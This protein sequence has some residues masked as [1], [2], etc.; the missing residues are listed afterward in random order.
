MS[1][2]SV[3]IAIII[4]LFSPGKIKPYVTTEAAGNDIVA[5]AE[6]WSELGADW[7]IKIDDESVAKV[8]DTKYQDGNSHKIV[9]IGEVNVYTFSAVNDGATKVTMTLSRK[10]KSNN[11]YLIIRSEDGKLTCPY[12]GN[13]EPSAEQIKKE[14]PNKLSSIKA[15]CTKEYFL[16]GNN[17]SI[18]DF[19]VTASYT[20]DKP[21]TVSGA[22][23][24]T[25]ASEYNT[26][27]THTIE[28]S[29]TEG[30]VTSKTTVSITV[31]DG[32]ATKSAEAK[33]KKDAYIVGDVFNSDEVAL[34]VTLYDGTVLNPDVDR[35]DTSACDFNKAGTYN[36]TAYYTVDGREESSR[37]TIKVNPVPV[38]VSST[39]KTK[40][41]SYPTGAIITSD[42][43]TAEATYSDGTK[44]S[45]SVESI[46]NAT[47]GIKAER[48]E[49]KTYSVY[50][51][52]KGVQYTSE[53]TV[54]IYGVTDVSVQSKLGTNI[55]KNKNTFT[56][57][58]FDCSI[59]YISED[60]DEKT[61]TVE[62]SMEAVT[63]DEP[64]SYEINMSA[65]DK[66][67][68]SHPLT[69]S[70]AIAEATSDPSYFNYSRYNNQAGKYVI[71]G[72]KSTC[73]A[74]KLI[75]PVGEFADGV[76]V[77]VNSL[78]GIDKTSVKEIVVPEGCVLGSSFSYTSNLEKITVNTTYEN[79][80]NYIKNANQ[81]GLDISFKDS[82]KD[83]STGLI[84]A[85]YNSDWCVI[86]LV[87]SSDSVVIPD[88]FN[89]KAVKGIGPKAFYKNKLTSVTIPDSVETVYDSAF[90]GASLKSLN[91][92]NVT[93]IK[94]N[95][96]K[97]CPIET[98]TANKLEKGGDYSLSATKFTQAEFPALRSAGSYMFLSS[99]LTQIDISSVT[100]CADY[101]F[102]K[103]TPSSFF[104]NGYIGFTLVGSPT[105][106]KLGKYAFVES[107][108]KN[109]TVTLSDD[110]TEIPEACFLNTHT[111]IN[112]PSNV[113]KLG[114]QCLSGTDITSAV[115]PESVTDYGIR[116]FEGCD[117]LTEVTLP[118]SLTRVENYMFCQCTA[119]TTINH[120]GTITEV[121]I[122][123]FEGCKFTSFNI[124]PLTKIEY[125]AFMDCTKLTGDLVIPEAITVCQPYIFANCDFVTLTLHDG[126]TAIGA[127]AFDRNYRMTSSVELPKHL[128]YFG[129]KVFDHNYNMTNVSITIPATCTQIGCD[130]YDYSP[131][132]PN[133]KTNID[134]KIRFSNTTHMLY[135][136]ATKTFREYIVEEGNP[137]YKA[138]D[139]VLFTKDGT[140]LVG[141]P[142]AKMVTDGRY[143]I[144]EGVIYLDDLCF[145]HAGAEGG[146]LKTLV[147]PDSLIISQGQGYN[148]LSGNPCWNTLSAAVYAFTGVEAYEVKDTNTRYT[149][150]DG[151]LYSKDMTVLICVPQNYGKSSGG[152]E[153]IIPD[154]VTT[155]EK[156]AFSSKS[157]ENDDYKYP[158]IT[159]IS[160]PNQY[161]LNDKM[162][163][164][165]YVVALTD[166]VF[167]AQLAKLT[168]DYGT[169]IEYR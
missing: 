35:I 153:L 79:G 85:D 127:S 157:T 68:V 119:L 24:T 149:S 161:K 41:I 36:A 72:V 95:A 92:N 133:H 83:E 62:P 100:E 40:E 33:T 20:N 13:E 34:K 168:K 73:D 29:Y 141:Y 45:F 48:P 52:D 152:K 88:S 108:M 111:K 147:L 31:I 121:G 14:I 44:K 18:S 138:V 46:K 137:N 10:N 49:K 166:S 126:I 75:L 32:K 102:V 154:S 93:E 28:I 8:T 134:Y 77:S 96:F 23:I 81:L 115:I 84:F 25:S 117:K 87:G 97:S 30:K 105:L 131:R 143:E 158:Y 90:E 139:G 69:F 145:S 38:I 130:F 7:K 101:A 165:G 27:G 144:P 61:D 42:D 124:A 125:G 109:A 159:K 156:G 160:L 67:G 107:D 89:G 16:L 50:F 2:F 43:I 169:V 167:R 5:K 136:F 53:V 17:I 98:I 80:Q 116:I 162:Y 39:A 55:F 9:G 6:N 106:K 86:G 3:F 64:G 114:S 47:E 150:V 103:T 135:D 82:V 129:D 164:N 4:L 163:Q 71:T 132:N 26:V 56:S 58:D 1:K 37:F 12:K 123:G 63:F 74:E 155:I 70:L 15:E 57:A 78:S 140:R 65:V 120:S 51:T 99:G 54:I 113:T 19:T 91:L 22:V 112:I 110:I 128:E 118:S 142:G 94:N 66:W 11:Y 21:K 59:S 146:N 60:G 104:G 76:C 148:A 151:V 122:C